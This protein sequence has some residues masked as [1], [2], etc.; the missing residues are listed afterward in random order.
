MPGIVVHFHRN[1]HLWDGPPERKKTRNRRAVR[2]EI[3]KYVAAFANADGGILVMGAEDNGA[4]TGHG[5][6]P[7]AVEDFL[8]VPERRLQPRQKPGRRVAFDG[9]E[10]LVFSVEPSPA[11]VMVAGD[12]FPFRVHDSVVLMAESHIASVKQQ[13]LVESA[14]S[15]WSARVNVPELDEALIRRA[16]AG[17][18]LAGRDPADYLVERRVADR[19]G[20]ALV[21]REAAVLL[22]ARKSIA[23]ANPHA[24]LRL[25]RVRGAER[26]LG[27]HHNVQELPR[28]EGNLPCLIEETYRVLS[29]L[30]PRSAK[31]HDLFFRE[32]PEYPTFAWQE[33]VVNAV[34]H[35]DYGVSTRGIEVWLYDDRLE[36][37]SPGGL[38]AEVSLEALRTRKPAHASRNPR[39]A[40]VLTELGFMREQGEGIPRMIEEMEQHWLPP[41][42]FAADPGEFRVVLRNTPVLEA[43]D[44]EWTRI[45]RDL[46]ISIR[47]KRILVGAAEGAFTNGDYQQLNQVDRDVAYREIQEL[48]KAKL[49]EPLPGGRGRGA[50]YRVARPKPVSKTEALRSRMEEKGR[51]ANADYREVFGVS[52]GQAM[53]AL[54]QLCERGV[55]VPVGRRGRGAHYVP[56][57]GW[58]GWR[59]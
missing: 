52:R 37:K 10:L 44:P 46:P 28:I 57:P 17:A 4:P 2:D 13:G 11:P 35:R 55:L 33:A 23:I 1:A 16:M 45:V 47:Q 34:A 54:R 32:M 18:G 48:V 8:A 29:E 14:E 38:L 27:A 30:I 40:R 53:E 24:G 42:E 51:V 56:G 49:V 22:F 59:E 7:A 5:Y 20:T 3:A 21:F 15:R 43:G 6:D 36:V 39:I 50:R 12:G 19:Q 25:F 26:R 31:L 58:S 9:V 41:P